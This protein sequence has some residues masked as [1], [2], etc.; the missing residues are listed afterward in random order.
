[1]SAPDDLT[2]IQSEVAAQDGA[3]LVLAGAGTGK[4]K[5]LTAAVVHRIRAFGVKPHRI[6]AVT[7]TNKAAGEMTGR[8]R[9]ALGGE[10][11]PGW[12]GTFHGLASRQLRTEPEVAGLRQGFDILDAED[13]RRLVRR[14]LK[15]MNLTGDESGDL[16]AGR[17][18]VKIIA[19]RIAQLK[20]RLIAPEEAQ[21][22][23]EW[24][25]AEADRTGDPVDAAGL[26]LT[27]RVYAD[28]QQRLGDANAAD[29]GDLLLW[30]ARTM[31]RDQAYRDRWAGRFDCVL[32]D[33]YQDV[34]HAQYIWLRLLAVEHGRIFVV[35][36]DDQAVF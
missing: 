17:D 10:G 14:I 25:I 12:L 24:V 30:P 1:M 15:A 21:A 20:D 22:H 18:P 9:S 2:P 23:Y 11:T 4:T 16:P 33:E 7:F 19:N 8:I 13:S 35:G 26:R 6:L 3:V 31:Q 36:D 34:N 5:T 32:A 29:F 28:Y 27:A